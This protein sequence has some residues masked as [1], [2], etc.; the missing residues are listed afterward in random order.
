MSLNNI[1]YPRAF[2]N[3]ADGGKFSRGYS[4]RVRLRRETARRETVRR[5]TPREPRRSVVAAGK[6]YDLPSGWA[7]SGDTYK[8]YD[9]TSRDT[10]ARRRLTP[11]KCDWIDPGH[12]PSP[13]IL[14]ARAPPSTPPP[15]PSRWRASEFPTPTRRRKFTSI[16]AT[17]YVDL[18][19]VCG[20]AQRRR[21][22]MKLENLEELYFDGLTLFFWPLLENTQKRQRY[23][24]YIY[25]YITLFLTRVR[26][27]YP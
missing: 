20:F 25:I 27:L 7:V 12:I 21:V 19:W 3:W 22:D 9:Y 17:S 1:A 16:A 23:I 11:R 2:G 26:A 14:L 6:P 18:S 13:S 24:H 4:V 15:L 10:A 5:L 8:S